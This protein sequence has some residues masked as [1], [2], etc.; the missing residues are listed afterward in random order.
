MYPWL[1]STP[2]RDFNFGHEH[3]DAGSFIFFPKPEIPVIT[4]SLYG[5]K[6][7]HLQN[8][9]EFHQDEME[10]I[11]GKTLIGQL[12]DNGNCSKWLDSKHFLESSAEILYYFSDEKCSVISAQVAKAYDE[13]W[14]I[15]AGRKYLI[16]SV[17]YD[18]YSYQSYI[19]S[20]YLR[21]IFFKFGFLC[22][23]D[24]LLG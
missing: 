16:N 10:I 22:K 21:S 14:L 3:P 4:P 11:C 24:I 18:G 2:L 5:P 9:F 15:K 13:Q 7:T 19:A 23:N 8:T 1:S 6:K 12:G 17:P 20:S